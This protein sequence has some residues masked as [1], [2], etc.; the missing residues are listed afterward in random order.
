MEF[1]GA[2]NALWTRSYKGQPSRGHV[3][4]TLC[5]S[6]NDC[7]EGSTHA[8]C[9]VKCVKKAATIRFTPGHG[10]RPKQ[11]G[12]KIAFLTAT[13]TTVVCIEGEGS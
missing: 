11:V 9:T 4:V 2:E 1:S 5:E 6:W 3:F 7:A 13:P 10:P 12:K 8:S